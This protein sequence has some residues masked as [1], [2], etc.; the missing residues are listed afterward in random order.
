MSPVIR[1]ALF[2]IFCCASINNAAEAPQASGPEAKPS[3]ASKPI[4][5][6]EIASKAQAA[7]ESLRE[8][9]SGLFA[10]Q[11]TTSVTDGLS[12]L[13]AEI[14][15][16]IGDDTQLLSSNPS[17]NM[18]YGLKVSWQ[19]FRDKLSVW[20]ND[21][22]RS[23]ISL[24]EELTRLEEQSKV[25]QLTLQSVQ[26]GGTTPE[27]LQRVKDVTDS[28]ERTQ[29]AVTSRRAQVLSLQSRISD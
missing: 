22:T 6:I 17:L 11:T 14:E 3:P 12:H 7:L 9:E 23:G 25:W 5:L 1:I 21:L 18:L 26:K 24:E 13:T 28:S 27:I 4:P 2:L 19:S 15:A 20:D 16:E 10:D 29:Q 8:I